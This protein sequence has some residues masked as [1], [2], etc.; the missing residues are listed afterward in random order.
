MNLARN[1][2]WA[3]MATSIASG[4]ALAV[5]V[6]C[7]VT[8]VNSIITEGQTLQLQAKCN[9]ALT[10]INWK[11]D[12]ISVTGDVALAGHVA[13]QPLY[14]TTPVG[15]GGANAF[16][17]TVTGTPDTGNTWNSST[18]ATVVVKPSSAVVAKAAGST[19]PTTPVDA[20]CGSADNT[21]VSAMPTNANGEQCAANSKPALAISGPTSFTW[22]CTSLTGGLEANCSAQRV[23]T[24]TVTPSVIGGAGSISPN[25]PVPVNGGS[26]LTVTA[27]PGSYNTTWGGTCG[28]TPNGNTSYTTNA[29]NTNCTVTATFTAA[30]A[31]INGSCGT[32]SGQTFSS[33]PTTALCSAGTPTS[34]STGSSYTWSCSGSNGGTTAS[35][36]ATI[37]TPPPVVGG[38]D[39]GTGSWWPT[40]TRLIAD[41][42]G[43][44]ADK[45]NYV[46]GCLNGEFT[47]SGT[48]GCATKVSNEGFSFVTGNVLGIRYVSKTALTA[49]RYFRISSGFGGSVGSGLKAWLSADPASTYESVPSGCRHIAGSTLLLATGGNYCQIQPNTRYYLFL[50]DDAGTA[51]RYIVDETSADFN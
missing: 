35:C 9:G 48:S 32:S 8:P 50:R 19:T 18:T 42:T 51:Q 24:Y 49:N 27:N 3:L 38:G 43:T 25:S 29:V 36:S 41:Q 45:L 15:L 6:D 28:G 22:S 26:S 1:L 5:A 16:A 33:P 34:V 20:T 39:P 23:V 44:A 21:S 4:H 7:T 2:R 11:M 40:S 37:A 46:P 10:H 31:A 14:Y 12:S 47:S 30:P 17:F 13:D